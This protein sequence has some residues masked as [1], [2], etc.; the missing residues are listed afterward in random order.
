MENNNNQSHQLLHSYCLNPDVR[1]ESQGVNERIILVLR[2]HPVTQIHWIFNVIILTILLIA[3]NF[4]LFSIFNIAQILFT[5]LFGII[6]ILSYTWFNFLTY[7]FN[8][9]VVTNQR[10]IDID[11][12][13]VLYKEVSEALLSKV[14]DITSK[15]G[16]Y[17]ES[18]FDY[19]DVFIQTAGTSENIEFLNIPHPSEVVRIIDEL[20]GK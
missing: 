2:A 17:F 20:L 8:V 10:I 18:F 1:V 6:M 12:T 7:F 4:F 13:S 16:G 11:Y 15:S 19:G 14:E 9:G 3:L 5:N